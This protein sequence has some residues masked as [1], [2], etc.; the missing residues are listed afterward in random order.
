MLKKTIWIALI[1]SQFICSQTE[2]TAEEIAAEAAK[3]AAEQTFNDT[4]L[5]GGAAYS[6]IKIGR[7]A[8][9][10]GLTLIPKTSIEEVRTQAI[11][12][13]IEILKTEADFKKCLVDNALATRQED[14]FPSECKQQANVFSQTN[15]MKEYKSIKH[16]FIESSSRILVA[17]E[18]NKAELEK[19]KQP[20]MSTTKKIIVG[21][22]AVGTVGAFWWLGGP[23][24]IMAKL[25]A[26]KGVVTTVSAVAG[27]R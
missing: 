9:K 21:G 24:I 14:W 25:V 7:T 4:L 18:K 17:L 6:A 15:S 16:E 10:I 1:F 13:E 5:L 2:K 8:Y 26:A 19:S 20:G 27:E 3:K 23:A 22:L 12:N 11:K